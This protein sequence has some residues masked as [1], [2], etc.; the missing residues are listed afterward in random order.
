MHAI[1]SLCY[2]GLV[3]Y[4]RTWH[5]SWKSIC[6]LEC[7]TLCVVVICFTSLCVSFRRH[8]L[9]QGAYSPFNQEAVPFNMVPYRTV[10]Y[11]M[12][13]PHWHTIADQLRNLPRYSIERAGVTSLWT[14]LKKKI[15]IFFK[16]DLNQALARFWSCDP[17]SAYYAFHFI[18]DPIFMEKKLIHKFVTDRKKYRWY[19]I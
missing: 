12:T 5:S 18:R 3:M 13:V 15:L 1:L 6:S 7:N 19:D 10:R 14:H 16:N 8:C 17:N 9:S 11:G 4:C 2:R